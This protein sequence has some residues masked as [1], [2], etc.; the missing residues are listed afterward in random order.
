[1]ISLLSVHNYKVPIDTFYFKID[2]KSSIVNFTHKTNVAC[3]L[4]YLIKYLKLS[5]RSNEPM[6]ST[7]LGMSKFREAAAQH[8]TGCNKPVGGRG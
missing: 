8:D 6:T 1:M 5:R 3:D 7:R 2:S 4:L